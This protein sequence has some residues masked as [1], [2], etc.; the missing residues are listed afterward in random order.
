LFRG[1]AA[2]LAADCDGGDPDRLH[3]A[4]ASSWPGSGGATSQDLA[5]LIRRELEV[6]SGHRTRAI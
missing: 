2:A 4:A 3:L 5:E 6:A 1:Q